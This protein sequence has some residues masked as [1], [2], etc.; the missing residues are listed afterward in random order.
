MKKPP[1]GYSTCAARSHDSTERHAIRTIGSSRFAALALALVVGV[2]A[3]VLPTGA[4]ADDGPLPL[5]PDPAV[6]VA[7]VTAAAEAV[8]AAAAAQT[9]LPATVSPVISVPDIPVPTPDVVVADTAAPAAASEPST[10]TVPEAPAPVA[11]TATT[12]PAL[13]VPAPVTP[14]PP[15]PDTAPTTTAPAET[16]YHEQNPPDIIASDK[17]P[18]QLSAP[19]QTWVWNW[20]WNCSEAAP[21]SPSAPPAGAS[22]WIW[23]WRWSCGAAPPGATGCELC[24]TAI[25]VRVFSPGDDG[26]VTQ[27]NAA[28]V[29]SAATTAVASTQSALQSAVRESRGPPPAPPPVFGVSLAP[30]PLPELPVSAFATLPSAPAAALAALPGFPLAGPGAVSALAPLGYAIGPAGEAEVAPA[31]HRGRFPGTARRA[32][33][34]S[35]GPTIA[36]AHA[37]TVSRQLLTRQGSTSEPRRAA[38]RASDSR[39]PAPSR[40]RPAPFMPSTSH[41]S[42]TGAASGSGVPAGGLAVLLG[43]LCAFAPLASRWLRAAQGTPPRAPY[44]SRP[45][46]PG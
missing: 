5:S 33:P 10:A 30:V 24:N 20:D 25:V 31:K 26:P 23:N 6:A 13:P 37:T 16:Q 21:A 45:E 8:V 41:V 35:R 14:E 22:T 40:Q 1:P 28:T 3:L 19:P 15:S 18:E 34:P 42:A 7:E 32:A 2:L 39:D 12:A 46:R 44:A 4:R 36:I 17:A 27:T 38:V 9:G 29:L 11:A 43:V